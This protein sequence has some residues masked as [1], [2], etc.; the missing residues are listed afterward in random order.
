[1]LVYLIQNQDSQLSKFSY[2]F[3]TDIM[4]NF[5]TFLPSHSRKNL[6]CQILIVASLIRLS[7]S[8]RGAMGLL[9][10]IAEELA[11]FFFP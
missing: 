10:F 1:M 8:V 9:S 6:F 4:L 11:Y 5:S 7:M 2:V 3:S